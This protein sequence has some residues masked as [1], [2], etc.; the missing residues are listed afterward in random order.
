MKTHIYS[1]FSTLKIGIDLLKR[2]KILKLIQYMDTEVY[3]KPK[4]LLKHFWQQQCKVPLVLCKLLVR[5][6]HGGIAVLARY[7]V[8]ENYVNLSSYLNEIAFK[9]TDSIKIE[10]NEKRN[11]KL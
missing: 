10:P 5:V 1:A 6:E 11:S 7:L 8:A 2:M 9:D 3:S 4:K